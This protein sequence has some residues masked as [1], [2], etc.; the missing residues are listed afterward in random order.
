MIAE[1]FKAAEPLYVAVR[2]G[3]FRVGDQYYKLLEVS[4]QDVLPVRKLFL[5]SRLV[6]FSFDNRTG[7]NGTYCA[8]CPNR[9]RCR[10]RIRLMILIHNVDSE[11]LPAVLEISPASFDALEQLINEVGHEKLPN[12]L[13][14]IQLSGT[15]GNR[16]TMDF[17][18][19]F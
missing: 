11:P 9:F 16:P 18:P 2:E 3:E 5:E 17:K 1:M 4:I 12:T 10:R 15:V 7:K 6:C 13:V 8:L 14:L 19:L